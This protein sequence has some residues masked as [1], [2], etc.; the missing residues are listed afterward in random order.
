MMFK[1]YPIMKNLFLL[2]EIKINKFTVTPIRW[3][4]LGLWFDNTVACREISVESPKFLSLEGC[5]A[6]DSE[7]NSRRPDGDLI[8]RNSPFLEGCAKGGQTH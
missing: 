1:K 4:F 5:K 2:H 3:Y 8:P 6:R 7:R